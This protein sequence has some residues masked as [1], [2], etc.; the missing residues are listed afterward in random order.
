MLPEGYS[1]LSKAAN[2]EAL[3]EEAIVVKNMAF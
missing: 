2:S 3:F 1:S